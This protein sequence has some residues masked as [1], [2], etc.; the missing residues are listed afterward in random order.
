MTTEFSLY[1]SLKLLP[2]QRLHHKAFRIVSKIESLKC[3]QTFLSKF[4][5]LLFEVHPTHHMKLPDLQ[6]KYHQAARNRRERKKRTEKN[7]YPKVR[8]KIDL[9]ASIEENAA[10]HPNETQQQ[11]TPKTQTFTI[12]RKGDQT[13]NKE[14]ANQ[15]LWDPPVSQVVLITS[16]TTIVG[17]V[18]DKHVLCKMLG[19]QGVSLSPGQEAYYTGPPKAQARLLIAS[20]TWRSLADPRKSQ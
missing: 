10:L 9:W 3:S 2:Q 11:Q 8:T 20:P 13:Q 17:C 5:P 12:L 1:G 18:D 6:M 16:V 4:T 15:G 14:P 7:K 19:N